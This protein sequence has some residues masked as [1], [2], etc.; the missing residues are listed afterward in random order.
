VAHEPR[1]REDEAK[2]IV[3]EHLGSD[4]YEEE[5]L[6]EESEEQASFGRLF[7]RDTWRSTAFASIFFTCL[8]APYFAIFTFA[9]EVFSSLGFDSPKFSIIATNAI[10]FLGALAGM[11]VIERV[12]RRRRLL[13]TSFWVMVATT[14]VIGVWAAGP[15]PVLLGCLVGFAFFNAISGDLTGVYPAEIFPSELRG[16]GVG[17]SAAV[18][19][20]G[21][22]GGTFLL[23]V[24]IDAFGIGVSM[25]IAAA[26]CAVGLAVTYLW[27][28]ETTDL[29]LTQSERAT[30]RGADDSP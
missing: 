22:A 21:A 17:F 7:A 30:P 24:G 23:P 2:A 14:L 13:L 18:S 5:D 15:V 20:I 25:L 27:A 12:G 1:G 29:S 28:P 11:V 9:P 26:V 8:V 16:S 6:P 19:R 3:D 10:A 4:Y